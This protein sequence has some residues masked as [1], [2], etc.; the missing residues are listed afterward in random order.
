[1]NNTITIAPT[2]PEITAASSESLPS[3][4]ETVCTDWASTFTGNAPRLSTRASDRASPSVKLPVIC[5]EPEKNGS[6]TTGADWMMSSSTIAN[7]RDGQALA[8]W[9]HC[10]ASRFQAASPSLRRFTVTPQAPT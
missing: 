1:M 10:D 6:L 3:V 9:L 5:T 8:P 4:G 2:M 7:C